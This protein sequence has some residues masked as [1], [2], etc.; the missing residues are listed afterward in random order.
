MFLDLGAGSMT[1]FRFWEF[2][3]LHPD[4]MCVSSLCLFV[5]VCLWCCATSHPQTWWFKAIRSITFFSQIYNLSGLEKDNKSLPQLLSA[6]AGPSLGTKIPW[7][8]PRSHVLLLGET[9]IG[10]WLEHADGASLGGLG[11]SQ[12]GDCVPRVSRGS[13]KPYCF[14]WPSSATQPSFCSS[15]QSPRIIQL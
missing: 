5:S 1:G 14:S 12:H 4:G 6:G 13:W 7:R 2:I 11:L 3:C 9:F 15:K 10:T 8:F